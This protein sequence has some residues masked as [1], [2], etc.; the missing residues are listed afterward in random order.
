MTQEL[1]FSGL[2]VKFQFFP[3]I[4]VVVVPLAAGLLTLQQDGS[5]GFIWDGSASK[6]SVLIAVTSCEEAGAVQVGF[7]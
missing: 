5:L 2:I 4:L 3:L 1:T 7:G 6:Q